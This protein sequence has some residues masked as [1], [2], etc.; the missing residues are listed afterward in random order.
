VTDNI[1]N[2][3]GFS[4][5]GLVIASLLADAFCSLTWNKMYFT[6]GLRLFVKRISVFRWHTNIPDRS[7]LEIMFHSD[8]LPSFSFKEINELSYGFHETKFQ[9]RFIGYAPLMHGLLTF[10]T[11]DGQV[12]VTGFANWYPL[13]FSLIWWGVLISFVTANWSIEGR[14]FYLL[15]L[16]GA[17]LFFILL[18]GLLYW[19]QSSR[20]SKVASYAAEAWKRKY[21]R[22]SDRA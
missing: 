1:D 3:I 10:D 12:V 16:L 20:F 17:T 15:I 7:R 21:V 14:S 11:D 6:S 4:A 5:F 2:I 19:I 13:A 22:E 9:F 8:W 18:M